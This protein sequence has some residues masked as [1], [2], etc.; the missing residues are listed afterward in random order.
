VR[1]TA[2]VTATAAEAIANRTPVAYAPAWA[3]MLA[4]KTMTMAKAM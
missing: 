1:L 4:L 2:S 3:S